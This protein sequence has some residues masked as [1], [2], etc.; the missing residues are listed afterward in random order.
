ME[1]VNRSARVGQGWDGNCRD[2]EGE[3]PPA[4][5]TLPVKAQFLALL[6]VNFAIC[7]QSHLRF[8][9]SFNNKK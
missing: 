2:G 3:C 8:C 7:Q 4:F 6:S 1:Q 5:A 9:P